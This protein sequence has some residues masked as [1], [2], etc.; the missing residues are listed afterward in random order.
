MSFIEKMRQNAKNKES[1]IVLALD[2]PFEKPENREALYKKAESIL[3]AVHPYICAVK[4]NHHLVLPLGLF[5]GV[6]KLVEKAH[7]KGLMAIMDCKVN[8]IGST[9]QI[10]AEYYYAAG[11]DALIANP[12]VGWEEGLKPVFEVARKMQRGVI[13]L[14]Y[15]SHKGA[16]E[17]YGQTVFNTETQEKTP[18]YIIF[19][20]KALKWGADGLVVGATYPEKIREVHR[21]VGGKIPIYSPGV[22][23]QG[24]EI[25]AALHAGASYLIVGRAIASAENPAESAAKVR[26]VAKSWAFKG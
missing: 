23:F 2:L 5:Q 22:G 15:M 13:L 18:Q 10:I 11:F 9:N 3:D 17:G 8:D 21:A 26:D 24:G 14:V 20:R 4:I 25:E 12:F 1:N 19:A 7:E 16:A 6:E